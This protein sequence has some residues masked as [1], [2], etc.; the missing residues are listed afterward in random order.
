[1]QKNLIVFAIAL[2]LGSKGLAQD[3]KAGDALPNCSKI[4]LVPLHSTPSRQ[5]S[6]AG[7]FDRLLLPDGVVIVHFCTPR[8]PFGSPTDSPLLAELAVLRRASQ[9]VPYPCAVAAV[10]PLGEKGRQ[11]T[12][13]LLNDDVRTRLAEGIVYWEPTYPRPGLFRTFTKSDEIAT[14]L[15]AI[16]AP[17]RKVLAIRTHSNTEPLESWLAKNLPPSVVPVPKSASSDMAMPSPDTWVWPGFRRTADHKPTANL[18]PDVLPYTYIAWETRVGRTFASPA[19]QDG[20]AYVLTDREGLQVVA[21]GSGQQIG[22][23]PCGETWW[24]SPVVSGSAVYVCNANGTVFCV[25]R[26]NLT[27]RWKRDVGGMITSSPIVQ[28]GTLFVG[29]RN[30]ALAA[31]DAANGDLLWRF[32]TGGE[33][34]SSPAYTNGTVIIGSGDRNL[35]CVDAKSGEQSWAFSTDGPIDSSPTIDGG[36]IYFGSFDGFVYAVK[37]SD[38]TQSWKTELGGWVHSS[39]AVSAGKVYAATVNWPKDIKPSF[40]WIE[41]KSGKRLGSFEMPDAVY[42]SPTVWGDLVLVG[43][44]NYELYAFDKEMKHTQPVWTFR[45]KSYLHASPVVVGDTILLSSFD[46]DLYALRQAK[47]IRVW[48][49]TDIVPRWFVSALVGEFHKQISDLIRKSATEKVGAE[50]RLPNFDSMFKRVQANAKP[51]GVNRTLPRD[52]P[53]DHPGAKFIEYALTSG[54]LSGFPDGAFRPEEPS[55]RF[56]FAFGES[57]VVDSV[58]RPEFVWRALASG[59]KSQAQVEVRMNPRTGVPLT[60]PEDVPSTHWAYKAISTLAG[61]AALPLDDEGSF[62]GQRLMTLKDAEA[63]WNQLADT[64]RIT[65]IR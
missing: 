64:I 42:S 51:D 40:N 18:L 55:T 27:L 49:Q 20:A 34:S 15:T 16:I 11:D 17:G 28:G 25:D 6:F 45:T 35:Y 14:P 47:P 65:R 10:V 30:G 56:Q 36:E 7:A 13:E 23:F 33:I 32:Q 37:L 5:N 24:S 44:R 46:A 59:N 19:V 3:L 12:I 52:V 53:A 38:G 43:C 57:A 22:N 61:K 21:I 63:F 39:P 29:S 50:L 54:L 4:P 2:L 1:M 60:M 26:S 62:K 8:V 41:Q 31:M 58:L 48:K 9:S